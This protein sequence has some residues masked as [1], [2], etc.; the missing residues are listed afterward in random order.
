[1]KQVTKKEFEKMYKKYSNEELAA[2]LDVSEITIYRH[3]KKLGLT[4][5]RKSL[6]KD[7]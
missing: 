5:P 6:I 2:K 1:M 3:A 7:M 4:K